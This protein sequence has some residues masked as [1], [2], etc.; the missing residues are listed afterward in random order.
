MVVNQGINMKIHAYFFTYNEGIILPF[1]LEHYQF[2]DK[3]TLIDG[4]SNDNTVE[5]IKKYKNTE[6]IQI[7][8][9]GQ[10]RD[11][12][13]LELRNNIW[14]QDSR[15]YDWVF[16]LDADEF[17]FCYTNIRQ[18]LEEITKQGFTI[19]RTCGYDMVS[20]EFPSYD[21]PIT[22]QI[23]KGLFHVYSNKP[24][25]FNPTK[26]KEINMLHGGHV[27][28][29]VGEGKVYYNADIKLLHYNRI[30]FEY[31]IR[32]HVVNCNRKSESDLKQG[33]GWHHGIPHYDYL[34]MYFELLNKSSLV[35]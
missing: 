28:N 5:I 18:R 29:P 20:E 23:K 33:W 7:D 16:I 15:I 22:E 26:I 6:I 31:A 25:I 12:I 27:C 19:I 14:K 10:I 3:I 34:Q 21:K 17:I 13:H 30:G 9:G 11:D 24:C 1:L 2:V 4:Q 35:I 32:K 8:S